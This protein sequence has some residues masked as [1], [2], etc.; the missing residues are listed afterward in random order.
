MKKIIWGGSNKKASVRWK[1]MTEKSEEGGTG[2]RDT[3]L[4]LDAAKV[5][6]LQKLMSRK[7]QPWMIWIEHK[8]IGVANKWGI[9]EAMPDKPTRKQ[10][11]K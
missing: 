5:T 9:E 10:R 6:M 1:I 11:K 2:I 8:L 3:I 4:T 7:R